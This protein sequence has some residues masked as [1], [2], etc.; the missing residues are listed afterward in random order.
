MST[1]LPV[2]NCETPADGVTNR[3]IRRKGAQRRNISSCPRICET[4]LARP[5]SRCLYPR[6]SRSISSDLQPLVLEQMLQAMKKFFAF[7]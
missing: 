7:S 4:L 6:S 3:W 5:M 1:A 2:Q